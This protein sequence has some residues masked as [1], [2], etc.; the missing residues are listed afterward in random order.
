MTKNSL[1]P[2][3]SSCFFEYNREVLCAGIKIAVIP[4]NLPPVSLSV[5]DTKVILAISL[6]RLGHD[7]KNIK[8]GFCGTH[9]AFELIT[10]PVGGARDFLVGSFRAHSFDCRRFIALKCMNTFVLLISEKTS[11]SSIRTVDCNP[12]G[13]KSD[14]NQFSSNNIH[15]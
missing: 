14:Q 1:Q 13:P 10:L 7:H 6:V 3:C 12:L 4:N 8:T 11:V 5:V 2:A 9:L 15:T